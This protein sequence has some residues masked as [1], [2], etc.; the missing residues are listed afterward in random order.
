LP[1]ALAAGLRPYAIDTTGPRRFA[2]TGNIG[3]GGTDADTIS[4]IDLEPAEPRVV[5]TVMVGLT[6]EGLKMS[7]DGRFVAVNVIN[8]SNLA[9]ASPTFSNHG[10]LQVWRIQAGRLRLVTRARTGSWGQGVAWSKDGRTIL[11]QSMLDRGLAAF[12]F[13]GK[14]LRAGKRLEMAAGPAAIATVE[15]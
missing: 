10:E 8:G 14:S 12:G 1:H 11:V 9:H 4:L 5:D 6:P 15:P 3:G 13:D 2:V 7:P